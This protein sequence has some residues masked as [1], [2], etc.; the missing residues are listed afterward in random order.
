MDELN[1]A[2]PDRRGEYLTGLL[3]QLARRL[4]SHLTSQR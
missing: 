1:R 2:E 4:A 3:V